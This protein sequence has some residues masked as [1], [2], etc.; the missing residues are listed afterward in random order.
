MIAAVTPKVAIDECDQVF[1]VVAA[2]SVSDIVVHPTS[3]SAAAAYRDSIQEGTF[4]AV[5]C[6][7]DFLGQ[8]TVYPFQ[9]TFDRSSTID[10]TLTRKFSN[11]P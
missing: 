4:E 10:L 5:D 7:N 1:D 3:S 8:P 9:L 11:N 6:C 2:S